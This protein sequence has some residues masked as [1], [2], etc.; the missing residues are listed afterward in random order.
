MKIAGM[1]W[2]GAKR[3]FTLFLLYI[4][5]GS[6]LPWMPFIQG[7]KDADAAPELQA[8]DFFGSGE[9]PDSAVLIEEPRDAY[10]VRMAL[11][12]GVQ[13]SL[14]IVYYAIQADQSGEAFLGEVL[15]AA[16]RGVVVRILLDGKINGS[17]AIRRDLAALEAHPNISCRLYNPLH[18][19]KLWQWH[20][21]MHNKFIL[22]DDTHLLTG[23]RNITDRFFAPNGYTGAITYDRD[24]LVTTDGSRDGV[25]QE[26]RQY[27]DRLWA[28][29]STRPQRAG[30]QPGAQTDR[31][32]A[33]AARI[34]SEN[35]EFYAKGLA[36]YLS[37]ALPTRKVTLVANPI[38][39]AKKTPVIVQAMRR[40]AEG[41]QH[42]V[43]LQTPYATAN[44]D[45]LNALSA[46]DE[47]AETVLLTNSVASSPNFFA[48]SNYYT[49]RRQFLAT[50]MDIYELQSTD[51]MHGK[52]MVIDHHLSVV[53]SLNLDDRSL[54]ID[55]ENM[56]F[57]DSEP[58]AAELRGVLD[59]YQGASLQLGA[60]TRYLPGPVQA[61][62]A[63]WFKKAGMAFVSLFSRLFQFLI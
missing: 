26:A 6:T 34:E 36:D 63:P 42:S 2:K 10:N 53:G 4:L 59:V 40:L 58:F 50:G 23:G 45:V 57:I 9:G 49:T 27:I 54:F 33:H 16:D 56:L 18:W 47:N 12:R 35:A 5:I 46:I 15:R 28:E 13:K 48:F 38:H 21:I 62:D 3:M 29:P 32:L 61:V 17:S 43:I 19:L 31:L 51:S 55:T 8:G 25:M 20:A 52:S 24:V 60:D 7:R 14:D 30:A 22:A 44:R 39:T 11:L 41:A 1:L 37:V